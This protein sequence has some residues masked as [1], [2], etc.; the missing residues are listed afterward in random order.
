MR[1]TC[2]KNAPAPLRPSFSVACPP[3]NRR[4]LLRTDPGK[5]PDLRP[6]TFPVVR[7]TFV[8]F[9]ATVALPPI[10]RLDTDCPPIAASSLEVIA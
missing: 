3:G 10:V 9:H 5:P 8:S 4:Q 2:P 1:E 6:F 7:R